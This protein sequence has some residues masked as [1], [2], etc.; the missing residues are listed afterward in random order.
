MLAKNKLNMWYSGFTFRWGWW[1]YSRERG[2]NSG[3]RLIVEDFTVHVKITRRYLFYRSE[4]FRKITHSFGFESLS[5]KR[6][7][8]SARSSSSDHDLSNVHASIKKLRLTRSSLICLRG[9]SFQFGVG[10]K[11]TFFITSSTADFSFDFSCI[12]NEASSATSRE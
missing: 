10:N 1:A 12:R 7:N 4:I 5:L 9:T 11:H 8:N 3:A 6:L 2:L